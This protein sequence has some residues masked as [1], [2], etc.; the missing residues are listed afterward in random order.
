MT[1]DLNTEHWLDSADWW[2]EL[3]MTDY[4]EWAETPTLTPPWQGAQSPHMESPAPNSIQELAQSHWEL[5]LCIQSLPSAAGLH[6]WSCG[7]WSKH[8]SHLSS[9]LQSFTLAQL[10]FWNQ[11]F[12][13]N[14][15]IHFRTSSCITSDVKNP[16]EFALRIQLFREQIV[17][18]SL[19]MLE[20]WCSE[21]TIDQDLNT[22]HRI[23]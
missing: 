15:N 8:H 11:H 10:R 22:H 1:Q 21:S 7:R 20:C 3:I 19:L 5:F 6:Y 23:C 2:W 4:V 9:D 18:M 17:I 16:H 12:H 14:Q 13:T